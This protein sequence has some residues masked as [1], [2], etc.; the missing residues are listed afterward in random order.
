LP[1]KIVPKLDSGFLC[2]PAKHEH[3]TISLRCSKKARQTQT[4]LRLKFQRR[5][6][7]ATGHSQPRHG[8]QW[9]LLFKKG[10]KDG[11]VMEVGH[12]FID[13]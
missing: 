7:D 9:S 4:R 12:Y 10:V 2:L 11:D 3:F 6:H 5:G 1:R 8:I 13:I